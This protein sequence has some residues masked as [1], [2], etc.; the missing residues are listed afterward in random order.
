MTCITGLTAQNTK[1]VRRVYPIEDQELIENCLDAVFED[2]GVDVVKTGMLATRATVK[3]VAKFLEKHHKD[4]LL[5]VDPVT[6]STSG[7][8]L[9]P[10]RAI[11]EMVKHLFPLAT[12][13][14]PNSLEAV[15]IAKLLGHNVE[16]PDT[17]EKARELVRIIAETGPQAVLLKGGH[18]PTE[19]GLLTDLLYWK[20]TF[21]EIN[22]Q[23][24]E[25]RNTHGTGCTLASAIA[26]NLALGHDI[27]LSVLNS[28]R[29]VHKAIATAIPLGNGHGPVNHLHNVHIRPFIR[30]HFIDYLLSHPKVKKYWPGYVNHSFVKQLSQKT[31]E[32]DSFKF[33]LRQDYKYLTHYA[34][35]HALAAYKA[36]NL[37]FSTKSAK[38][39][40]HISNEMQLHL[41]YCS[42]F[43]ITKQ[44]LE[45][46]E[47]SL[48]CVAY[49]RYILD[50]G[51]QGD[52]LALQ[53]ALS[54]CLL[55]YYEAARNC[56][57][58]PNSVKEGNKYWK[59]VDNYVAEDYIQAVDAGRQLLEQ[60]VL[61]VSPER[62]IEL[63]EIFA[64]ATEM[65]CNFWTSALMLGK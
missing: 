45:Q 48:A 22:N 64:K 14:T 49:S 10:E 53:M 62:L 28:V 40:E 60:A 30:G 65:E 17:K 2:V 35:A 31:L 38:I 1:G 8:T 24:I 23:Y 16:R 18:M 32:L 29:F 6:I 4:K 63:I 55:G 12:I 21:Y 11:H 25:S 15:H 20:N 5:V 41:K 43:G 47:E 51:V 42:Q 7:A 34:R 19:H 52:W 57:N 56:I 26:S 9:I 37:E 13:V 58:D 46:T 54:P 33:F 50:I 44:E 27:H 3:T 39:I 61:S 36:P 59:W